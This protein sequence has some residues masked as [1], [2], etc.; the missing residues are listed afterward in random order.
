MD[1]IK[2]YEITGNILVLDDTPGNLR[3]L[4]KLLTQHGH[5]IRP[6]RDSRLALSSARASPPDLILL[7]IMMPEIDGFDVCRQ[8]K[9]DDKTKDILIIFISALTEGGYPLTVSKSNVLTPKKLRG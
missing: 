8:L 3:L 7:D 4:V 9:Q 6:V 5:I 1:Q 2:S